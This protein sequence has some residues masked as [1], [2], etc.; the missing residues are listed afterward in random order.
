VSVNFG[1]LLYQMG[2]FVRQQPVIDVYLQAR[3]DAKTASRFLQREIVTDKLQSYG[4][5]SDL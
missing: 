1:P 3:R 5:H 4:G 2:Q